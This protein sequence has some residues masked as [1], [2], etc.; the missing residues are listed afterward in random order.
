MSRYNFTATVG[1]TSIRV[2]K[3]SK[4]QIISFLK[5][6]SPEV[7]C[8]MYHYE[9]A[10]GKTI[11]LAGIKEFDKISFEAE[12]SKTTFKKKSII[13]LLRPNNIEVLKIASRRYKCLGC[14]LVADKTRA[15]IIGNQFLKSAQSF[16]IVKNSNQKIVLLSQ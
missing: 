9:F 5:I 11:L 13:K 3:N 7:S 10:I 1:K 4:T 6:S 2:Y 15:D 12:L 16:C 14:G 8:K